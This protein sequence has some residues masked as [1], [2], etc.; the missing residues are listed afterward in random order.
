MVSL[1]RRIAACLLSA[2]LWSCARDHVH[3]QPVVLLER[4]FPVSSLPVEIPLNG[5]GIAAGHALIRVEQENAD[6]Q[7]QL[8][9]LPR[10]V[11]DAPGRRAGPER[12]CV[13]LEGRDVILRLT[14]NESSSAIDRNIRLTVSRVDAA[15]IEPGSLL[16]A[17]C[18]ESTAATTE[19]DADANRAREQA[20][21]YERAAEIWE[22][23]AQPARAAYAWLQAGWSLSRRNLD[24]VRAVRL[25]VRARQAFH[26]LDD[27][28]G[29]ALAIMQIAVPR[30]ELIDSG[31][32][33]DG[34]PVTDKTALL[35]RQRADLHTA[36]RA[37][38]RES[39]AFFAADARNFLASIHYQA[40]DLPAAIDTFEE[41]ARQFRLAG[42][43]GGVTRAL[44]NR[45]LILRET[46]QYRAAAAAFDELFASPEAA[47]T[48]DVL[49]DML[50]N[51]A[52][53]HSVAGNY[54]RALAQ[55][56][57]ALQIH[58]KLRDVPG[59]ARSLNGLSATYLR[60]GNYLAC[61]AYASRAGDLLAE[62]DPDGALAAEGPR[63]MSSLLAG[64]A[65]RNLGNLDKA[66]SAHENALKLSSTSPYMRAR[67]HL[68]L[69]Q[70]LLLRG[71]S[72]AARLHLR[73]VVEQTDVPAILRQ[74]A[75]LESARILITERRYSAAIAALSGLQ[76][77]FSEVGAAEHEIDL[78]HLLS[79]AQLGLGRIPE[80]LRASD[81][82]VSQLRSLRL[83][84]TNPELRVRLNEVYRATYEVRVEALLESR[85]RQKDPAMRSLLLAKA[86]AAADDARAG[87]ARATH[88]SMSP[89]GAPADGRRADLQG[90]VALRQYLLT[91]DDA[92]MG[93]PGRSE[94]ARR[95]LE[96]LR[97]QLDAITGNASSVLPAFSD[98]DYETDG[99]LDDQ[100]VLLFLRA[101]DQLY[102]FLIVRDAV[103]ELP[104]LEL[105]RAR[106]SAENALAEIR[107]STTPVFVPGP[108]LRSASRL[109]L[110][111]ASVLQRFSRLVIVA[112]PAL[113]QLPF[114][115]LHA[116]GPDYLPLVATHDLSMALTVRDAIAIAGLHHE[117]QSVNLSNVV[118]F[119]DPVFHPA[120]SRLRKAKVDSGIVAPIAML[121]GSRA[122]A[123]QIMAR[124]PRSAVTLY[125]DF[126]A[127]RDAL[128]SH[129]RGAAVLHLATHAIANDRWP[130]GSGLLLTA[131]TR[132]GKSINNYVS[133]LDLMSHRA[134]AELVVLS[135]CE[136][137]RGESS[138]NEVAA[139]LARAFLGGGARRV[140]AT[141]WPVNDL[142]TATLMGDFYSQLAQ[143]N[144]AAR[145]LSMAQRT[146]LDSP[147]GRSPR[148]WAAFTVYEQLPD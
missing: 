56:V 41:A 76:N 121:S 54:D 45:A 75:Q 91:L 105:T 95:E 125:Q 117:T 19:M 34:R 92:G 80:A 47:A 141:L 52:M 51:S 97:A 74:Q 25:G 37:F 21:Q 114:A 65:A 33:E 44:A 133:T 8:S 29:A 122:E 58:E 98:A 16:E 145:A 62:R 77:K 14:T 106:E 81:A 46:G 113:A 39:L 123:A 87:L 136:T 89:A 143:G 71:D 101:A 63:L 15:A 84:S 137:A 124:L 128:L 78:L 31:L 9:T 50:D 146:A 60:L 28:R 48:E 82:G 73:Q 85:R 4:S 90:E 18:L 119:A 42:E 49:S 67:A 142:A 55:F 144:S 12:A 132:E 59:Q 1:H 102:R 134:P 94:S 26:S 10:V 135:A 148:H 131:F 35:D 138:K 17:E 130:N 6:V 107:T 23:R 11:F 112:D 93:D 69:A 64:E 3:D 30:T 110:P 126:D 7:L 147:Q 70:D 83:A 22:K 2:T 13:A 88:R 96:R 20:R 32:D 5:T 40:N 108:R 72:G 27:A 57:Q 139:G 109:F 115:A 116:G 140:I 129:G 79:R 86:L 103:E 104:T 24:Y 43:P 120:D 99:L 118:V 53:T 36:M 127:T 100:A 111:P 38:D 68:E 66:I 61:L